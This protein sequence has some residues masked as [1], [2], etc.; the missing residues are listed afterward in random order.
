MPITTT[1]RGGKAASG[2]ISRCPC[3]VGS[4][5]QLPGRAILFSFWMQFHPATIFVVFIDADF[6][7]SII[8]NAICES[9]TAVTH[10]Y[11]KRCGAI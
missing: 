7:V 3:R 1:Y 10:L 11:I 6:F 9:N 4:G 5:T 8:A 2:W